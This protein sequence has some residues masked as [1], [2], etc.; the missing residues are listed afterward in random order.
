MTPE[1]NEVVLQKQE[2][3]VMTLTLN[4]PSKLNCLSRQLIQ[5][6]M[7]QLDKAELDTTI[8]VII[9]TGGQGRSFSSGADINELQHHFSQGPDS[10]VQ[11]W[12]RPGQ[13]L[14]RRI[15]S[16]RKPIICAINGICFGGG[17]EIVEASH[18][19]IA[20][21]SARFSK[22]EIK[23]GIIPTFGGTQRL[24]RNIGRKSALEMLL[25]GREFDAEE[26]LNKGLINRVVANLDELQAES[27]RLALE[28]AQFSHASIG[29]MLNAV[30]LGLDASIDDGLAIEE[31]NFRAVVQEGSAKSKIDAFLARGK[32]K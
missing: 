25:T 1:Q 9:L 12:L 7:T 26:A 29:A 13:T 19:A 4:R 14:T 27:Q 15:E 11:N 30:H 32:S 16:F 28:I 17:C 6:L 31:N 3:P 22:A 21:Q 20:I 2:G 10:T 18:L 24:P 8:K 23:I 5:L